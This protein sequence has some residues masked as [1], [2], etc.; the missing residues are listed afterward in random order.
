[1]MIGLGGARP[2]PAVDLPRR[3]GHAARGGYTP[4]VEQVSFGIEMRSGGHTFQINVS[5]GFGTTLG[6]LARGG[7]SSDSWFIGFNISRKFF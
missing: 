5:N 4:G 2:P 6:Q 3:R 1:M 7:V